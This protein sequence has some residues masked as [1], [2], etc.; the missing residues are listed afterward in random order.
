MESPADIE[1]VMGQL[2]E[3]LESKKKS[4][5]EREESFSRRVRLFEEDHPKSG[6][7]SDVLHLNIG[8]STNIA[9]LRRI[10]TQFEDSM[11]ASKFSGRWDDSIAKDKDGNFFLDHDPTEFLKLINFLRMVD[12][13]SRAD[14]HVPVPIADI[15]FCWLL[16][17]YGLMLSVYPPRWYV[18]EHTQG[19]TIQRPSRPGDPFVLN[20]KHQ[21]TFAL[22]LERMPDMCA[23]LLV[24]FEKGSTGEA[25]WGSGSASIGAGIYGS[26]KA[27][28]GAASYGSG[29]AL[30]ITRS[31]EDQ[32]VKMQSTYEIDTLTYSYSV[33]LE[34]LAPVTWQTTEKIKNL[35]PTISLSGSVVVSGMSYLLV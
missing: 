28:F 2:Q 18:I 5:D 12:Q 34:D 13:K 29:R 24:I 16:E 33:Q 19:T 7:D 10:L 23:S 30:S 25:S 22:R 6:K 3:M 14:L 32:R 35:G 8:G 15:N 27:S 26:G 9:V 31:E 4:L 20:A 21:S 17:Y 1:K 11:L